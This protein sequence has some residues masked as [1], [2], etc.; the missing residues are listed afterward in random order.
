LDVIRR[1]AM[2]VVG[3][4]TRTTNAD[5]V[6]PESSRLGHLWARAL[7][8]G[9]FN[10]VAHRSN[11]TRLIAV[12]HGYES[13]ETGAYTQLVGVEVDFLDDEVPPGMTT[14]AVPEAQSVRFSA[15][16]EMPQAIIAAWERIWASFPGDGLRRAFTF[17]V[18]FH[19]GDIDAAADVLI[20]VEP[21]AGSPSPRI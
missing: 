9:A 4:Q 16:G 21:A 19:P 11:S 10:T 17:D 18:E 6:S 12:L 7:Q 1:E 15:Q 13:D 2:Q 3:Y 8:P 14:L 5:E 20:A